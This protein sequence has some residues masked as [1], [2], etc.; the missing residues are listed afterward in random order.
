MNRFAL[1]TVAIDIEGQRVFINQH[2]FDP[3]LHKAWVEEQEQEGD[4][5]PEAAL[6]ESSTASSAQKRGKQAKR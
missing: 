3:A 4:E 2:E 6:A 1:P 5:Q